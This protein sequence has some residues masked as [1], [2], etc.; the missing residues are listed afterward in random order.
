MSNLEY[1]PPLGN[2]DHNCLK[3][4]FHAKVLSGKTNFLR[5]KLDSGNYDLMRS[6]LQKIDW[7]VIDDI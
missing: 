4:K 5:Y 6:L 1:L 2:N 7:K 3:F